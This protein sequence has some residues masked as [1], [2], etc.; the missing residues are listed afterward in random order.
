M[1]TDR[2]RCLIHPATLALAL[3]AVPATAQE[4]PPEPGRIAVTGE[5]RAT[6][7]PDMA[8]IALAVTREGET[9]GEALNATSEAMTEVL[10]AMREIGLEDRDVQ[11]NDVS[12]SPVYERDDGTR[13]GRTRPEIVGYTARNGVSVRVRDLDLLGTVIDRAV[14]LGANEGGGLFFGNSDSEAMRRE[15]RMLAVEDARARAEAMASAAGVELGRIVSLQEG[16]GFSPAPRPFEARMVMD[17][18]AAVPIAAGESEIVERVSAVFEI[19]PS[20]SE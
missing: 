18:A 17:E 9:A 16:G 7:A 20:G 8:T 11:T 14:E 3:L 13:P 12:L 10:A 15:A 6:A 19:G 4:R 2:F 5:G 1:L